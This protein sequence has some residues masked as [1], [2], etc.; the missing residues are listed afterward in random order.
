MKALADL[1]NIVAFFA[2]FKYAESHAEQVAALLTPVIGSIPEG[3]APILAATLTAIV[4]SLVQVLFNLVTRRPI[5]RMFLMSVVL[6][7]VFG[8][9]TLYF[10]N[11]MFIKW[12]PTI[13]YLLMG[14]A[15]AVQMLR[16]KLTLKSVFSTVEDLE[17]S[18]ARWRT[19][20]RLSLVFCLFLAALNLLVAY[21][22]STEIWVNFKLFGLMGLTLLF[23]IAL[24][25]FIATSKP[26]GQN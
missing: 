8:G 13:L 2:I 15:L 19:I 1:L 16:G 5:S 3:T 17:L 18:D 7:I 6:I 12:K 24:S 22:C 14:G 20:D 4:V 9:M 23:T 11:E 26:H 21:T 10:H 25:V